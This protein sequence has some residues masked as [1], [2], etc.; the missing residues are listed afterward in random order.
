M[1][2]YLNIPEGNVS[3]IGCLWPM[4][5]YG[6]EKLSFHIHPVFVPQLRPVEMKGFVSFNYQSSS[7]RELS[8]KEACRSDL[9]KA[10]SYKFPATGCTLP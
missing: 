8:G 3:V 5:Y 4:C 6:K 10:N 2:G 1:K 9:N 7:W